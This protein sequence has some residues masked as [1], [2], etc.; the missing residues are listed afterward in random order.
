MLPKPKEQCPFRS[1]RWCS[2]RWWEKWWDDSWRS[3]SSLH[4]WICEFSFI[5]WAWLTDMDAL[6]AQLCLV[7]LVSGMGWRLAVVYRFLHVGIMIINPIVYIHLTGYLN[8][9]GYSV[10]ILFGERISLTKV[11]RG[12]RCLFTRIQLAYIC[13]NICMLIF[14]HRQPWGFRLVFKPNLRVGLVQKSEGIVWR[15]RL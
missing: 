13:V 5:L 6:S 1:K 9:A 11:I 4:H 10:N 7:S 2:E 3:D 12:W 8:F 14:R 15:S